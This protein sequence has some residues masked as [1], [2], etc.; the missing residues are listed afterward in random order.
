MLPPE[1][2]VK[3]RDVFIKMVKSYRETYRGSVLD[4]L[5]LPEMTFKQF[6]YLDAIIKMNNPTYGDLA[7]KFRVTKPAVTATVNKLINL[8]YIDRVQSIEDRRVYHIM[9]SNKGKRMLAIE[10]SAATDYVKHFESCITTYEAEQYIAIAEKII[11]QAI[12][13]RE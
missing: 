9:I 11:A 8:G 7:K 10:D 1:T 4:E 13:K 12:P 6:V 2:F 3:L 5:E